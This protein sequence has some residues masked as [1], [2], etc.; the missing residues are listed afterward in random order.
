M[1][2]EEYNLRSRDVAYILDCSPDDCLILAQKG[3]I[4][5]RRV[6]RFWRYSQRSVT[7]YKK[8]K[9]KHNHD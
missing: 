8:R 9:E 2:K 1:E 6:G 5:A 4:A 3:K 7:A